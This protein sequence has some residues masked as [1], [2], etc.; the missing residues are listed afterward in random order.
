VLAFHSRRRK[1]AANREI[2][3]D[4]ERL[5][6]GIEVRAG[7]T[8]AP[9]PPA[10]PQ[11]ASPSWPSL[12]GQKSQPTHSEFKRG[13]FQQMES[14]NASDQISDVQDDLA[15]PVRGIQHFVRSSG[16]IQGKYCSRSGA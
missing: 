8:K 12:I 6:L 15:A 9:S 2:D 1:A 11:T 3:P 16:L 7:R 5:G 14:G 4:R 10:P 13:Y